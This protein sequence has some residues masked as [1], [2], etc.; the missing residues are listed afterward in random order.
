MLQNDCVR[1]RMLEAWKMVK[2]FKYNAAVQ[3]RRIHLF[4]LLIILFTFAAVLVGTV[5]FQ[6]STIL[7]RAEAAME[8]P[9]YDGF[10]GGRH[11]L[12]CPMRSRM[13]CPGA[14]DVHVA[15]RVGFPES[16]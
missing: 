11:P 8:E 9:S 6:L 10:E 5:T 13:T 15:N 4:N 7:D 3:N 16:V 14:E 1:E 12:C 2:M